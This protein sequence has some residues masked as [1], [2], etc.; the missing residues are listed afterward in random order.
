MQIISL[1]T[2]LYVS[3]TTLTQG[4]ESP[5]EKQPIKDLS[6]TATNSKL[7][8]RLKEKIAMDFGSRYKA[9]ALTFSLVIDEE[10]KILGCK[11]KLTT[12]SASMLHL[13]SHKL[14]ILDTNLLVYTRKLVFLEL[15]I[16]NL[17]EL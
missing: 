12:R 10:G 7:L 3:T 15:D 14:S 11:P 17:E 1:L 8:G 2:A 4:L 13:L 16:K 9:K 6:F 5:L